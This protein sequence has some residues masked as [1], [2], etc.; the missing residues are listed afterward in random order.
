MS[1]HLGDDLRPVVVPERARQFLVRHARLALLASPPLGQSPG[2]NDPE[3]E[4][5]LV[6]PANDVSGGRRVK[7]LDQELPQQATTTCYVTMTTAII[8]T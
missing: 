6:L 8:A 3:L 7:Q 4:V 2:V 5:G 1:A